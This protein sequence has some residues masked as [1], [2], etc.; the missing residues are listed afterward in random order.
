MDVF[1]EVEK[2]RIIQKQLERLAKRHRVNEFEEKSH[3]RR[4]SR[5][6]ERTKMGIY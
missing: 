6:L 4:I 2:L 1:I 3:L 5:A